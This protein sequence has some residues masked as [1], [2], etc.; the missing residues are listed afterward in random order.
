MTHTLASP[1]AGT[2]RASRLRNLDARRLPPGKVMGVDAHRREAAALVRGR[3]VQAIE[4]IPLAD[5]TMRAAVE[6]VLAVVRATR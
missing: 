2:H 5:R 6:A 3:I 4:A 1:A